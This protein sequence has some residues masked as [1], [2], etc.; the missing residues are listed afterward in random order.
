MC[1][2][3]FSAIARFFSRP[4]LIYPNPAMARVF[5]HLSVFGLGGAIGW[6]GLSRAFSLR[7]QAVVHQQAARWGRVDAGGA[8]HCFLW[9][10]SASPASSWLSWLRCSLTAQ[11]RVG[12]VN[13]KSALLIC[14]FSCW[15]SLSSFGAMPFRRCSSPDGVCAEEGED[16]SAR[17]ETL[18]I[19]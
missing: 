16:N 4:A 14:C 17:F 18:H 11:R 5:L 10:F 6:W 8:P 7:D 19:I 3:S 15:C 12:R 2:C 9:N 13:N 1:H